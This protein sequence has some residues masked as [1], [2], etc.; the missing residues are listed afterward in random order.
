MVYRFD[1]LPRLD[2]RRFNTAK[3]VKMSGFPLKN[4]KSR[5]GQRVLSLGNYLAMSR[6]TYSFLCTIQLAAMHRLTR[7]RELVNSPVSEPAV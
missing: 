7:L 4:V 3:L 5:Q 6:R 1:T 2:D